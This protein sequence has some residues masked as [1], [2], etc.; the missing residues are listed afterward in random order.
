MSTGAESSAGDRLEQ[1]QPCVASVASDGT[2]TAVAIGSARISRRWGSERRDGR[3]RDRDQ[4]HDGRRGGRG[5]C[6]LTATG[7]TY[8]WGQSPVAVP[9]VD[10]QQYHRRPTRLRAYWLMRA[11][12]CGDSNVSGTLGALVLG[13]RPAFPLAHGRRFVYQDFY[14]GAYVRRTLAG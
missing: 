9:G 10:L 3:H 8:C 13:W 7:E 4:L 2:V 12:Y 1:Q 5:N 14:Y 6:G 11:A